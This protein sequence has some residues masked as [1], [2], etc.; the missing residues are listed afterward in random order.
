MGQGRRQIMIMTKYQAVISCV[1][2]FV[3]CSVHPFGL[4]ISCN[5]P[6]LYGHALNFSSDSDTFSGI[7]LD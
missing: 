4:I 7:Y 1:P 2:D 3:A 6:S 5:P